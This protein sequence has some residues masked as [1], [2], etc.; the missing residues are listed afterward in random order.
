[1][2]FSVFVNIKGTSVYGDTSFKPLCVKIGLAV[3]AVACLMDTRIWG[4]IV[5]F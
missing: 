3:S 1:M 2:V 5:G 4:K